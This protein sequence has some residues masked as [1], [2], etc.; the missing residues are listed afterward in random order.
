MTMRQR[1][2]GVLRNEYGDL[3]F[4]KCIEGFIVAFWG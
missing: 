4:G 1:D 3:E 2:R